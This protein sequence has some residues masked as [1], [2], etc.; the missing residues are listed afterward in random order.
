[1]SSSS[2]CNCPLLPL[3]LLAF[4]PV[5]LAKSFFRLCTDGSFPEG[6]LHK[7]AKSSPDHAVT[8]TLL[9]TLLAPSLRKLS[10]CVQEV[11]RVTD[12]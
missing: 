2:A 12:G 9:T 7:E 4:S 11:Q 3:L 1:M 10:Q 5:L 6:C 8:D